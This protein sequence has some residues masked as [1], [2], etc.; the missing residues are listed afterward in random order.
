[1]AFL[2]LGL[3]LISIFSS[4][5]GFTLI[6][7]SKKFIELEIDLIDFY[8]ID[9]SHEIFAI[10]KVKRKV[11]NFKAAGYLVTFIP[12][13]NFIHIHALHVAVKTGNLKEILN[14]NF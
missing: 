1:M 11:R 10:G 7:S 3:Y 14:Q 2:L 5:I 4:I 13:F 12:I 8:K 9:G 6:T